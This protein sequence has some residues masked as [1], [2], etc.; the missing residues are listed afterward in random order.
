M[1]WLK[2]IA[3]I[4]LGLLGAIVV[5]LLVFAGINLIDEDLNPA[6]KPLLEVPA[7]T[8]APERNGYLYLVGFGADAD[9]NPHAVG[10]EIE[11]IVQAYYRTAGSWITGPRIDEKVAGRGISIPHGALEKICDASKQPCLDRYLAESVTIAKLLQAN[12]PV[13][14]RYQRLIAYPGYQDRPM[15]SFSD[16]FPA[17]GGV[18]SASR[19]TVV[20]AALR[21]ADGRHREGAEA[22]A[23]DI[24]FWRRVLAGSNL[25]IGKMVAAKRIEDDLK[26]LNEL[27]ARYPA[28]A[29]DQATLLAEITQPLSTAEAEFCGVLN[30][31]MAIAVR[32]VHFLGQSRWK[33]RKEIREALVYPGSSTLGRLSVVAPVGFLPNASLN[34]MN[35]FNVAAVSF[36][37][38][39]PAVLI[40][41]VTE[42]KSRL[43]AVRKSRVSGMA[44]LYNPLGK[45]FMD[46]TTP[47]F[48]D[49]RFRVIDIDGYLRA[50][51]LH[52]R[53]RAAGTRDDAIPG[54]I[55]QA[56][57][58]YHDPYTDK[59]IVWDAK[60]RT[61][62]ITWNGKPK[63]ADGVAVIKVGQ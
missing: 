27:I 48:E 25:L 41:A 18:A 51:A 4:L 55:A 21:V 52:A 22:I 9:K 54:L 31:E 61:L 10:T 32:S 1:N 42:A 56:G 7:M 5:I 29:R 46:G 63:K 34:L 35:D 44:L 40:G 6:V 62:T 47:A 23:G 50:T 43:D 8:L 15:Y 59:P 26:H 45:L 39:K 13:L 14:V 16:P 12:A 53:I 28:F 49:Y 60:A 17:Y 37:G 58:A 19:L 20:N 3:K 2:R 11:K 33:H 36:C 38:V 30:Q 57:A 24:R